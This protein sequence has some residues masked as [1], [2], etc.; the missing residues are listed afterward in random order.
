MSAAEPVS[1]VT[2]PPSPVG[3]DVASVEGG[4]AFIAAV[5]VSE[6]EATGCVAFAGLEDVAAAFGA[7]AGA[8]RRRM[9]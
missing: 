6:T 8:D 3:A 5:G 1:G 4:V 2:S 7:S 9:T